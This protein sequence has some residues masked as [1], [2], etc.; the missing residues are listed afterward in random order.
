[1]I[2]SNTSSHHFFYAAVDVESV[3][4]R[5]P[6]LR[7]GWLGLGPLVHRPDGAALVEPF[8][9][10]VREVSRRLSHPPSASPSRWTASSSKPLG[11]VSR[12]LR[13]G[14]GRHHRCMI[15]TI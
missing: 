11:R 6:Q 8:A 7:S 5:H 3:L 2:G 1:L 9:A 13:L 10:L 4:I 12:I 15:A 14:F